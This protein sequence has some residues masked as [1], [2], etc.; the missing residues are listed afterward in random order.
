MEGAGGKYFHRVIQSYVA[1]ERRMMLRVSIK[2]T[3]LHGKW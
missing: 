3:D 1:Y 2:S